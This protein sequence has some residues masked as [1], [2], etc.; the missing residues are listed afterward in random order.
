MTVVA[1]SRSRLGQACVPGALIGAIFEIGR[2]NPP[3]RV[4][5]ASAG[6]E[7]RAPGAGALIAKSGCAFLE[8]VGDAGSHGGGRRHYRYPPQLQVQSCLL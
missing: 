4:A 7:P 2:C 8:E 3:R 5:L 1:Q 6:R